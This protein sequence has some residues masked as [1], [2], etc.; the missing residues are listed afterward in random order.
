MNVNVATNTE[1]DGEPADC[2]LDGHDF[3]K[4]VCMLPSAERMYIGTRARVALVQVCRRCLSLRG[5][6]D[7][8]EED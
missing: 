6:F 3:V 4:V 8:I 2:A 7:L 5:I 1:L